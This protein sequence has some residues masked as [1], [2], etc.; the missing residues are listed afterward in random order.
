MNRPILIGFLL[1]G[2][3]ATAMAWGP[4]GAGI[5]AV[6]QAAIFWRLSTRGEV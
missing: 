6:V 2:L 3:F 1:G 5:Y 4:T